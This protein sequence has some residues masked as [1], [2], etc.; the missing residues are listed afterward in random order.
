M[1]ESF[2][3][4]FEDA[5]KFNDSLEIYLK[6]IQMLAE[7]GKFTEMEEKIKKVRSKHKQEPKMWLELARNYYQLKWYQEARNLKEACLKSIQI[8]KDRKYT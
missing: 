1:Q 4:T 5:L 3:K 7:S 6:V 8:K 2:E